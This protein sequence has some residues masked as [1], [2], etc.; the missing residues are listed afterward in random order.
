MLWIIKSHFLFS[1][2]N[3]ALT[4]L[5]DEFQRL[6]LEKIFTIYAIYYHI[7][8]L[9]MQINKRMGLL[10]MRK[11]RKIE[12]RRHFTWGKGTQA[13]WTLVMINVWRASFS[14]TR[15][16]CFTEKDVFAFQK[17]QCRSCNLNVWNNHSSKTVICMDFIADCIDSLY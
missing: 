16:L 1:K 14:K 9:L 7:L 8:T 2:G 12:E 15:H 6:N 11:P 4:A 10:C 13:Y 5:Y 3:L 17:T